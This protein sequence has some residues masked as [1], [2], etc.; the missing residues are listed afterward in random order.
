MVD[1]QVKIFTTNLVKINNQKD[2]G[3][4]EDGTTVCI[5]NCFVYLRDSMYGNR[6]HTRGEI[7]ES[8][9]KLKKRDPSAYLTTEYVA[10]IFRYLIGNWKTEKEENLKN[11]FESRL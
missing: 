5:L 11:V 8:I 7:V 2:K 6:S 4:E 3:V 9:D 10:L 1:K